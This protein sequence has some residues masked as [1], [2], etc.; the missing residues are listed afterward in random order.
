[1][2][3]FKEPEISN[4]EKGCKTDM[5]WIARK[6]RNYWD[7]KEDDRHVKILEVQKRRKKTKKGGMK[8]PKWS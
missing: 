4:V 5:A 3:L 2:C 8:N 1:M 6:N 7:Y